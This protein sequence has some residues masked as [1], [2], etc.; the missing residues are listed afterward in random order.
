MTQSYLESLRRERAELL[1]LYGDGVRPSW[2][3]AELARIDGAI[4]RAD[5]SEAYSGQVVGDK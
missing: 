5:A 4:E 2:V 1:C 3:S